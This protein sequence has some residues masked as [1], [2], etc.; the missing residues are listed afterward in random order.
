MVLPCSPPPPDPPCVH[1][2]IR[3][4]WKYRGGFIFME[5][6]D[7]PAVHCYEL[8]FIKNLCCII[9]NA[10]FSMWNH[11]CLSTSLALLQCS[12]SSFIYPGNFRKLLTCHKLLVDGLVKKKRRM[13]SEIKK[14]T[15]E[16]QLTLSLR[17]SQIPL[18][19]AV[20]K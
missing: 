14:R 12:H 16:Q 4:S 19:T 1:T 13:L 15:L 10:S 3:N 8:L 17:C 9:F 6:Q 5:K 11:Q 7:F 18:Y 20:K 2:D